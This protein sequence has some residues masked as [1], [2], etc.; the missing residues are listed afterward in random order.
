MATSHSEIRSSRTSGF[1]YLPHCKGKI[2]AQSTQIVY[3]RRYIPRFSAIFR[4]FM[5]K[6]IETSQPVEK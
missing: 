4:A 1:G 6:D 2:T 3:I 5:T